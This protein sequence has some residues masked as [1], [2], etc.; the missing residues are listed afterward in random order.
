M[1]TLEQLRSGAL[2]G[3]TRLTLRC[4]LTEFPRE[5]Y[6]LA[7]SLEILDLSGNALS[8]LPDD[9]PRLHKLRIIFCSD[10]QF[11]ELP[12]VLG[13]CPAL[14]MVGFKANQIRHVPA[15]ALP[16]QLRWLVLTD[17]D[18]EQLP[19]ALGERPLLQKLMLAG[20]RLRA[21]PE[22]MAQ[23]HKLELLRIASNRLDALPSWLLS[24]PRLTW[25]A[26][27]GNP[28]CDQLEDT[29]V[30]TP[31]TAISWPTLALRDKLGEGA[32]GVIYKAD[33]PHDDT[34]EP[35]A[36][37]LFK[38]AM[39]SDGS[40]LSEMAA[41]LG[42][43][44]HPNL[45]PVLGHIEDHP[46]GVHGLAMSLISPDFH[47]LAGPPSLNSCTRDIYR[48]GKRFPL[49]TM[50]SIAR[51]I[52]SAAAQ[53]HSHGIM[54]GDLYGHNVLHDEHGHTLLGDFGAASFYDPA[55][56]HAAAL[57]TLEVRAFGNLLEELLDRC[58]TDLPRL[59]QLRDACQQG[60]PRFNDIKEQ[61]DNPF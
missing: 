23:L 2:A 54:H 55:G 5:I 18:L 31:S 53:L 27:A 1:H 34:A 13:A 61:L 42:A 4:G 39:T 35:V 58:D 30:H 16:A 40:P 50:L 29:L 41:C 38:G 12:P 8:S 21:L 20:N 11:T 49:E 45:I 59:R 15:A 43:G 60:G 7:D 14:T 6:A 22:S 9:L 47:N 17:N 32:S 46:D 48:D 3:I 33:W 52:A 37:K 56:P 24:L 26:Y 10:N 51:G 28:L 19:A 25:L 44:A 36:V 57:Q